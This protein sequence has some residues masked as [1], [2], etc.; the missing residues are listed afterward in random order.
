[1]SQPGLNLFIKKGGSKLNKTQPYVRIES[2]FNHKFK[3]DRL[4][5]SVY[6]P[7][8]QAKWDDLLEK[9]EFYQLGH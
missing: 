1:M 9:G 6:N 2:H 4:V 8:H 3:M 7:M 5:K